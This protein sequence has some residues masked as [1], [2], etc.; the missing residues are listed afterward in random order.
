VAIKATELPGQSLE[1]LLDDMALTTGGKVLARQLGFGFTSAGSLENPPESGIVLPTN[2]WNDLSLADLGS[3]DNVTIDHTGT[4]FSWTRMKKGD[5]RLLAM[6]A[7]SILQDEPSPGRNERLRRVGINPE[8]FP[9]QVQLSPQLQSEYKTVVPFRLVSRYFVT[10]PVSRNCIMENALV[11]VFDAPLNDIRA[12]ISILSHAAKAGR[13]LLIVAPSVSDDI[14]STCVINKLRG[15]VL[16]AVVIPAAEVENPRTILANLAGNFGTQVIQPSLHY[17]ILP[18]DI[19][20]LFG[21][22]GKLRVTAGNL[23]FTVDQ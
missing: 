12:A 3:A 7:A 5:A 19:S 8:K 10:D 13:P 17:S 4:T 15:I 6:L 11:A 22:I 2:S 20:G 21:K 18:G 16:C 14:L 23:A 9:A 1:S